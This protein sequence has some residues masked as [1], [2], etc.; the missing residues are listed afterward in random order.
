MK[1]SYLAIALSILLICRS[2]AQD[3]ITVPGN[4]RTIQL[5]LNAAE[6]GTTILVAPGTYYENLFWP[7]TIDGIKLK[8]EAGEHETI[9]DGELF[10]VIHIESEKK[11]GPQT[12][13]KNTE[14]NGFTIQNGRVVSGHGA[15]L[16]ADYASPTLRNLIFRD[17][18]GLTNSSGAGAEL[19]NFE[20]IIEN[21]SF[22]NNTIRGGANAYAVGLNIN[23]FGEVEL[24]NCVFRNN[25]GSA[26]SR[27]HGGGLAVTRGFSVPP[28]SEVK[29][30]NCIFDNNS[31]T[32]EL[33]CSG[34]GLFIGSFSRDI[35]VTIDSCVI[36]N[37]SILSGNWPFGA[38]MFSDRANLTLS[39]SQFSGNKSF[40][41]SALYLQQY[42]ENNTIINNTK[43]TDNTS[44]RF[45]GTIYASRK[46]DITMN[47]CVVSKNKGWSVNTL[48]NLNLNHCTLVE[49]SGPIILK[50]STLTAVNSVFWDNSDGLSDIIRGKDFSTSLSHCIVAGGF[51]GE[52]IIDRDP[53]LS[54]GQVFIPSLGSP[55]LGSGRT[56]VLDTDILGNPRPLPAT[57]NPDIGA[58]EVDKNVAFLRVRFY[59][60]TNLDGI[61]DSDEPYTSLG[62]VTINEEDFYNFSDDGLSIVVDQGNLD[63]AYNSAYHPLWTTT[64]LA[65]HSLLVDTDDFE[66]ELVFGL[67][68][69]ESI[70]NLQTTLVH[71]RFRCGD[72]IHFRLII[73]NRGTTIE[74]G[75]AWISLDDRLELFTFD[76]MPDFVDNEFLV[77]WN[78]NEL[79]PNDSQ[80]FDFS[81]T[82]PL[83]DDEEDTRVLY[84]FESFG[85]TESE[86][87]SSKH[88]VPNKC[89]F[90]PNDKDYSPRRQDSL[91]LNTES[92]VYRIRFQNTG[93]DYAKNVVITDT[94][95]SNLDLSTFDLI[96]SSHEDILEV[97]INDGR[98]ITFTFNE[99]YL[100]DSLS[101]EAGSQGHIFYS[102]D[103]LD[104]LPI[105]TEVNN[106]ANI[107]FDQNPAIRTNTTSSIL[108]DEFP[109]LE[110]PIT[111]D[112]S[113]F[114][115][116]PNPADNT[117]SVIPDADTIR[118]F[119]A[120]GR[121]VL[122]ATNANEV[123][124][125]YLTSGLYYIEATNENQ[126]NVSQ[127]IIER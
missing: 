37:N 41:G 78:F 99:I 126:R 35:L 83:I 125:K 121:L 100:P 13:T 108:V 15:G 96:S 91:S 52:N 63:V 30:R 87:F 118:I 4:F 32:S 123:D 12:I 16:F 40:S 115:F 92:Q 45:T 94:I 77:G 82:A 8:S 61:K 20:G 6:A 34:G 81:I 124:T 107:F 119:D 105:G 98:L 10:R 120:Q 56:G 127:L 44:S 3:T 106:T 28:S 19:N 89:A 103:P 5:A 84:C 46:G 48:G 70:S 122:S 58:Y 11:S 86:R 102:I 101:N 88:F 49:N 112:N 21:C 55:C 1:N 59:I 23:T 109:K 14:I 65:T 54:S 9:I 73:K 50:D 93:N 114:I 7:K 90:D 75:V 24:N 29:I 27:C 39:N 80:H 71:E 74:D 110:D 64:S 31:V 62:A 2:D 104:N 26:S 43:F 38:G 25:H 95:S 47:N 33:W 67:T 113:P 66:Q 79:K 17:N 60:D 51:D 76:T 18:L 117:V 111:T 97:T 85:V 116:Y 57:T 42:N 72:E 69:K 22:I 36:S 53:L 68:P